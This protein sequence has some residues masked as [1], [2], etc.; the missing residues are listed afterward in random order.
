MKNIFGLGITLALLTTSCGAQQSKIKGDRDVISVNGTLQTGINTIE[1]DNDIEVEL[2]QAKS[3]DYILTTDR[4]L[5]SVVDFKVKD[6]VLHINTNMKITRSKKLEVYLKL[7]NPQHIVLKGDSDLKTPGQ[8]EVPYFT[9][10]A[11]S[12]SQID[13]NITSKKTRIN[14]SEKAGGE[15]NTKTRELEIKMSGRT[16]LDGKFTATETF[17]TMSDNSEFNPRGKSETLNLTLTGKADYKGD[18]FDIKEAM[19]TLSDRSSSGISA[20]DKLMVS[21]QDNAI[22][23]VYGKPEINVKALNDDAQIN[24]R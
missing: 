2:V 24:K 9:A 10:T 6:S 18:D 5:I 22:V 1:V 12:D 23:N 3:N 4:N 16:D 13:L 17:L 21:A 14:L 7:Q 11:M 19:L 20:S 8:I 15:V